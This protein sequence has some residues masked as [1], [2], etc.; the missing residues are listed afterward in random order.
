[1]I[2]R[3]VEN[4]AIAEAK[5]R[6][7]VA[8]FGEMAGKVGD[9]FDAVLRFGDSLPHVLGA[10]DLDEALPDLP[11]SSSSRATGRRRSLS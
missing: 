3:A 10:L 4:A 5:A 2:E 8:G 9:R 6:F 1:M 11:V 7:L